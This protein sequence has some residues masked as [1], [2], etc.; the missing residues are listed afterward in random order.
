V[1]RVGALAVGLVAVVLLVV[2]QN[3]FEWV[4]NDAP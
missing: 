1:V 2:V 4:V 3:W